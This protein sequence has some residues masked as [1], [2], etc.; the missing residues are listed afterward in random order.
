MY[1]SQFGFG[2]ST[3]PKVTSKTPTKRAPHDHNTK[4]MHNIVFTSKNEEYDK[5]E[6]R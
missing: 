4:S 1:D 5:K 3:D 6:K 2:K